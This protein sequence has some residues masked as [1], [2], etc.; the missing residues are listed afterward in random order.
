MNDTPLTRLPV[1]AG[2]VLMVLGAIDPLEGSILIAAGALLG[3][4]GVWLG[5]RPHLRPLGWAVAVIGLLALILAGKGVLAREWMLLIPVGL[6]LLSLLMLAWGLRRAA[7]AEPL[8]V[9]LSALFTVVGVAALWVLSSFGGFG[10][11][12][13]SW[14]WALLVLPFP[15][16]WL[17]HLY[18][19]GRWIGE[20]EAAR[21]PI[22]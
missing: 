21:Q 18:S 3:A 5:G 9:Y 6:V 16:G 10:H 20:G 1:Y 17:R 8:C 12:A 4:L 2:P 22:A 11:G 7:P 14:W 13:L 15:V 19:I